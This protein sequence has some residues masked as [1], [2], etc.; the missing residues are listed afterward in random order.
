MH[1]A[2][3]RYQEA[4][5]VSDDLR[6]FIANRGDV[7][8]FGHRLGELPAI[9]AARWRD[10]RDAPFHVLYVGQPWN[11]E[12]H[13]LPRDP[14]LAGVVSTVWLRDLGFSRYESGVLQ[15]RNRF[16]PRLREYLA[17]LRKT[18]PV[19][20]V[21][22]YLSGS[23]IRPSD[24]AALREEGTVLVG[25]NWDDRLYFRGARVEG[26]WSGPAG[27]ANAFDLNLTNARRSLKKYA[28]IGARAMFWPEGANPAMFRP[29]GAARTHDVAFVGG[30]YGP[31]PE[32]V[33]AL[34]RAGLSVL[35]RGPGWPGGEA[36]PEQVPSILNSG[37]IVLGFSG[38]GRSLRITCLKGRD[39]E[40]PMCGAAYLTSQSSE[41]RLVYET[42]K[43]VMTW[44]NTRDLVRTA[45]NLL[46]DERRLVALRRAGRARAL[47]DHTWARRVEALAR[48]TGHQWR[49]PPPPEPA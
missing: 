25:F 49:S 35:A 5:V 22:A 17:A 10:I 28:S 4:V 27:T 20:L 12:E 11:W 29:T 38:I 40:A 41:L 16:G 48:A 24:L 44:A 6:A 23:Q 18:R 19:H 9:A 21:L 37:R 2:R 31:R 30:C 45:R 47:R 39:F 34:E 33:R 15:H 32:V 8:G 14:G 7:P 36:P 26:V 13:N 43:E 1:F 42:G 3:A 46:A